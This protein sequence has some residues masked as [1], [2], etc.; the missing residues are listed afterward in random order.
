MTGRIKLYFKNSQSSPYG[1]LYV[2]KGNLDDRGFQQLSPEIRSE[3]E[4]DFE[5]D[6]LTKDLEEIRRIGKK[7]FRT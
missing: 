6:A 2:A 3:N 7:K 1:Y 5:I 4:L